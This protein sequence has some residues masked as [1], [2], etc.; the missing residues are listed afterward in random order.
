MP[1][2]MQKFSECFKA[3]ASNDPAVAGRAQAAFAKA[4][5]EVIREGV[6]N[7][8]NL[9]GIF[10]TV[11]VTNGG[12]TKEFPLHFL[13]PGTEKEFIAYTIPK[14]GRIPER[15]IESDYVQVP[16][17]PVAN[18]ID[19]LLRYARDAEWNVVTDALTVFR[20]GFVKKMNDDGWHVLLGAGVDRNIVVFDSDS[21]PGQFTKR[22]VSLAKT[23]MRRNGGGNSTSINRRRLTDIFMSPEGVEDIRNWGV[24]MVDEVTRRQIW[25]A[26]D[27]TINNIFGVNLH[28]YDE[29]GEGQEYQNYYTNDLSGAMGSGDLEIA[30]GFDLSHRPN[31]FKMPFKEDVQM[32]HDP[33]LHRQQ[34]D[35]YYGWAE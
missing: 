35:G 5:A 18:S 29:F 17:F 26:A 15:N 1:N 14:Q 3:T 16:V 2:D 33:G 10:E 6:M 12:V 11:P 20:M 13:A 31:S 27:G 23:V 32:F 25:V 21:N 19:W 9:T 4:I 22:L 28:D 8:D 34:R 30:I 7:G 24:D